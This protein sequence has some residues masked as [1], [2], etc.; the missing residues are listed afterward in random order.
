[1]SVDTLTIETETIAALAS[2]I[3]RVPTVHPSTPFA[4]IGLDSV[5]ALELLAAVE[6]EFRVE[7]P[8][9][10][11]VTC[12]NARAMATA[13]IAAR[14]GR[15]QESS[16]DDDT[17]AMRADS[18]LPPD[19]VPRVRRTYAAR[20]LRE[21]NTIL[22]TGV[23]GF[24]GRWLA[25]ELLAESATTLVCLVRRGSCDAH[26]RAR[27]ALRET[28]L[29]DNT[30]A[31]RV[32][33][34]EGDL[35]APRLGMRVDAF[36]RLA[37]DIDA[38]CHVGADVNWVLP[39]RAL[40][41]AN[42]DGTLE[43]LRLACARGVSFHFVSSLSVCYGVQLGY[44]H[45]KGVSE[46]L[47]REAGRR[48]LPVTTY[49]P[50]LIAGHSATG[51]SNPD[52]LLARVVA[53]CV[54]MG[55]A[56]DLDWTIDCVPVDEIARDIVRLSSRRGLF[57]LRHPTPRHWRECVLWMRLSGYN[58]RLVPYHAWL[59]QLDRETCARGSDRGL[60]PLVAEVR[61]HPLQP[62]RSFFLSRPADGRGQ[63]LPELMLRPAPEHEGEASDTAYAPLDVGLLQRYFDALVA[64]GRLPRLSSKGVRPR[65]D[66]SVLDAA[67]FSRAIGAS[68]VKTEP[69]GRLSEHSIIGELTSW[70]AGRATGL[71]AYRLHVE[72]EPHPREV[73]V[74]I[75]A[76][77]RDAIAVGDALARLCGDDIGNAY[78]GAADRLGLI[79]SHERELAIYEQYDPRFIA[80][81]PRVLAT[82]R[83]DQTETWLVILER[84]TGAVLQ[85]AVDD[86]RQWTT[87]RL[88]CAIRGVASLHAIWYGRESELRQM[89]WIGHVSSATDLREMSDLWTALARH[90]APRF[91]AWS[92]PSIAGIQRHLIAS[93]DE[94][95]TPLDTAPRTLI[96]N[97]FNPRNIC[98]RRDERDGTL[99]L[100]AY[101]WEL[102]TVCVPQRDLAELLCFVLPP[103]VSSARVEHWIERHRLL[104]EQEIGQRL[105]V[106]EWQQGFY[107]SLNEVMMT[108][109]P[110]YALIHRVRPQS[111]LPRVV[112]TWYAMYGLRLRDR[113][114]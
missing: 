78:A 105:D 63:T 99:K 114:R 90:A 101:D 82:V 81:T 91:S 110:M 33:V 68:V 75:K 32:R 85:D 74:K 9:D 50:S 54:H 61:P 25:R 92:H 51:A 62:L 104:L 44:A 31:D 98:L 49:R 107:A 66:P 48:G 24:L 106:D 13:V 11:A 70:I 26:L 21:A 18:I 96:H 79:G 95:R 56:P 84:I 34:I 41:G 88:D 73:V 60:T 4:L 5:G 8:V 58:V 100:A 20:G 87:D 19:V 113:S 10:V 27:E 15:G 43:L 80:R 109:L 93:Q 29:S 94:W 1:M 64:G 77:D 57:T 23:T 39:Y 89:P 59:A 6:H 103:D 12:R 71:F 28:G 36:D 30:I 2:R 55:T 35:T 102:A 17:T 46:A 16:A 65:S 45:T 111:F 72:G 40:K 76:R 42:V 47:V 14:S 38:V 112:R 22:L 67:F 52:D 86:P 7:L 3:A 97:D 83:D 37:N 69:I 53:G 108:R